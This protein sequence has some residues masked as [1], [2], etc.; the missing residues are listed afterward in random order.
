M[1]NIKVQ[2][3]LSRA[4]MGTDSHIRMAIEDETSGVCFAEI[5]IPMEAFAYLVTGMHG[6]KADCTLRG[7]E[8]VGMQHEGKTEIIQ[9]PDNMPYNRDDNLELIED[10]LSP[11][12]VDGWIA[13]TPDLFNHHMR[14]GK[15]M[16]RV[17]FH[18]YVEVD[19]NAKD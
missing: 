11:Y 15:N 13:Y 18:R 2:L 5:E 17:S 8:N 9:T 1:K 3:G 16:Q 6:I 12:E 14:E 4:G 10:I 7:L 19:D